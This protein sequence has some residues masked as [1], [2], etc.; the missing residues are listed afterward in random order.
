MSPTDVDAQPRAA[1]VRTNFLPYSET[2]IHEQLRF[3]KRYRVK[4]FARQWRNADRFNGHDVTAVEQIP[5]APRPIRST[6]FGMTGLSLRL[7]R[8]LRA[9]KPQIIHAHFGHNG[10][11]A[12]GF[13]LRH[14]L[15]LVVSLHGRDV[16]VL[17]G[18]DKYRPSYW[19]YLIGHRPLF[20]VAD[21]FLAASTELRDLIID[22]GCPPE[23]VVVHRLG[24]DVE[25]FAPAAPDQVASEPSVVMVGRFVEKKG[26][27]D[28]LH[29][30]ARAR[31]AGH[32]FRLTIIGDGPLASRYVAEIARLGLDERVDLPGP[33]PSA[34]VAARLRAATVVLTPSVIA[35]NHDRESGLIVA[36]EA[37]ACGVPVVGTLHGGIPD[38]IDDGVTGYLVPEHDPAALGARLSALLGDPVL[39]A[40][41]GAAARA[42]MLSEYDIRGRMTELESI[43]DEVI[44]AH[45]RR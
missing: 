12:M 2:F 21:R 8:A 33:L 17:V 31:D 22:C 20:K 43:Y 45:G 23:K 3:H 13:A 41:F 35:A 10:L 37:A 16:T 29:A 11:Y 27:I 40:R 18:R 36:K 15:P 4:V 38:I 24:I 26:H 34:E 5:G 42:K 44:A 32:N 14:R 9:F 30:A 39:R 6:L 19:H 28:G 25:R 1:L 7:E